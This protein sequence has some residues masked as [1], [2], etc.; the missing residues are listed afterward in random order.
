MKN[1]DIVGAIEAAKEHSI[2]MKESATIAASAVK[3][4]ASTVA[5]AVVSAAKVFGLNEP[6]KKV[7]LYVVLG[8]AVT[9]TITWMVKTLGKGMHS[10]LL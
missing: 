4:A 10:P 9:F 8:C 1:L 2:G 3:E 6:Q 7:V 5:T